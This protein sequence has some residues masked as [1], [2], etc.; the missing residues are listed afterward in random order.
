MV[1]LKKPGLCTYVCVPLRPANRYLPVPAMEEPA[2]AEEPDDAFDELPPLLSGGQ[3][4]SW[5]KQKANMMRILFE[6][7]ATK[8]KPLDRMRVQ[9]LCDRTFWGKLCTYLIEVYKSPPGTK[10]AG[11]Y[12]RASNILNYLRS[13]MHLAQ[14]IVGAEQQAQDFFTCLEPNSS[15]AS[16][17][18]FNGLKKNV[19]RV[20]FERAVE[21]GDTIDGSELPLY[22]E[23]IISISRAYAQVNTAEAA[24]VRAHIYPGLCPAPPSPTLL[25]PPLSL[26]SPYPLPP[27][28]CAERKFAIK[29]LW[30][31][32]GR[33]GEGG[34]MVWDQHLEWDEY[35]KCMIV[36][37]PMPKVRHS[38]HHAHTCPFGG[39][40]CP[41]DTRVLS[42]DTG[43]YDTRVL[44]MD[45]QSIVHS[46]D[47]HVIGHPCPPSEH[48]CPAGVKGEDRATGGWRHASPLLLLGHG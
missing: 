4:P 37:V 27:P 14:G 20:T 35:Y 38:L 29:T 41:F 33:T 11:K 1:S 44:L 48:H 36:I 12:L 5:L 7:G 32:A 31:V 17:I 43:V 3:S 2:A 26:G 10:N 13:M 46:V 16:A 19:V 6:S 42:V 15:T 30:S 22:V 21:N 25:S 40:R 23:H 45:T 39:H 8:G 28:L 24:G 9:E 47:T 18:W 34:N